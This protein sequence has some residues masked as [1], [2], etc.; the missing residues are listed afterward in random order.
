MQG[1]YRLSRDL[2]QY[3]EH[4]SVVASNSEDAEEISRANTSNIFFFNS[5]IEASLN[6]FVHMHDLASENPLGDEF[7]RQLIL[8]EKRLSVNEKWNL[9]AERIG[10][11]IWRNDRFP[12]QSWTFIRKLRNDLVHY[13][14]RPLQIDQLPANHIRTWF[15]QHSTEI[16]GD[17]LAGPSWCPALL[18][19]QSL[20]MFIHELV[21]CDPIECLKGS[22]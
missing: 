17:Q 12:F 7:T 5:Y 8:L 4:Y 10:G 22:S 2:K 14:A 16:A 19:S 15:E 9:I 1:F 6:E 3:I 11:E 13:K 21:A 18:S 20:C